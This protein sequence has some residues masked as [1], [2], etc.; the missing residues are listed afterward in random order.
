[1]IKAEVIF[2]GED[3]IFG[4]YRILVQAANSYRCSYDV[5]KNKPITNKTKYHSFQNLEEAIKYC[6]EHSK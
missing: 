2:D 1:M 3:I 4:E 6:V 5:I